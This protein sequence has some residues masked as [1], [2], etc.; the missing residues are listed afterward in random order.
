VIL[1]IYK[2]FDNYFI[3]QVLICYEFGST[4]ESHL[5]ELQLFV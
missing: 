2:L 3:G 4:V 5:S 1:A